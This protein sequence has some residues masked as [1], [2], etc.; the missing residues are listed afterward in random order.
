MDTSFTAALG[1]GFVLGLRHAM[2]ADH[3]AA[4]S[5]LASREQSVLRSCLL[6][7]FWGAGHTAAL[8]A[9]AIAV[10]AFK[11]AIPLAL[12]QALEM[13]VGLVLVLLGG[14]VLFRAL[15][16]WTGHSH[17]HAHTHLNE[18]R[19]HRHWH[20]HPQGSAPDEAAPHDHQHVLRLASRPFLIGILHG[21][22][23][24]AALMLLTLAAM[25]SALSAFIYV[26][27]FGVGSTVGML[28]LSGLIGIPFVIAAG[29]SVAVQIAIQALA[30]AFSLGLGIWLIW[31]HAI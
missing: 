6:G 26:L 4:V 5:A 24:S 17:H 18:G 22:A 8:L 25:P 9:A 30:G 20:V 14:H 2:D 7:T 1:L 13:G 16:A 11:L 10:V 12:E 29:R 21:L 31:E 19:T 23:G 3:V 15:A 28:V 27:L